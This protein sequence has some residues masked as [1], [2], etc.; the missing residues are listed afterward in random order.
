MVWE[1]M[2]IE[3]EEVFFATEDGSETVIAVETRR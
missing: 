1:T 2:D 3:L